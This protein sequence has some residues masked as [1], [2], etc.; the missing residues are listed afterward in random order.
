ME[1]LRDIWDWLVA[2]FDEDQVLVM[3]LVVIS[4]AT[5]VGSLIAVPIAVVKMEADFFVR[6]QG[7][8]IPR[9]P[10]RLARRIA[11]N[12]LGGL[13]LLA[14]IAMLVLP[15]QGLLTIAL[16]VGLLDFPGKRR[17]QLRIVTTGNVKR[18]IN[19]IRKKADKPPLELP[20]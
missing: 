4:V 3:W 7:G 13:M 18:S 1:A 15:G 2:A 11:K 5:F 14:G 8:V 16:G 9:T 20:G 12:G 6:K 10:W 19:W 17:L